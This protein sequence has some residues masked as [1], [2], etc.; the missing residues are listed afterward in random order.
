MTCHR[1]TASLFNGVFAYCTPKRILKTTGLGRTAW[2]VM[3]NKKPAK[4]RLYAGF[5]TFTYLVGRVIGGGGVCQY[6][7]ALCLIMDCKCIIK[8]IVACVYL[9]LLSH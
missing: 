9:L 6:S 5:R 4:A 7:V 1:G 8:H 3:V 2:D